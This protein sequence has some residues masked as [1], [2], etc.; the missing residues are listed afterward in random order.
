[1]EQI[2]II[3]G[4]LSIGGLLL[5]VL[6]AVWRTAIK[7]DKVTE[8]VGKV[9]SNAEQIRKLQKQVEVV[10]RKTTEIHDDMQGQRQTISVMCRALL[11]ILDELK[12]SNCGTSLTAAHQEMRDHL[13]K[14]W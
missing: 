5:A 11:A 14:N 8:E 1:M 7:T 6:A 9:K 3:R 2:D 13:T 12:S 4:L 10:E